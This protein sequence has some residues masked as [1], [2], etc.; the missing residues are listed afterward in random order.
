[1]NASVEK[2]PFLLIHVELSTPSISSPYFILE[3]TSFCIPIRPKA[4]LFQ[5]KRVRLG[6]RRGLTR[7]RTGHSLGNVV[8]G[9]RVSLFCLCAWPGRTKFLMVWLAGGYTTDFLRTGCICNFI[10][11]SC[12][13]LCWALVTHEYA[14]SHPDHVFKCCQCNI[15]GTSS[16]FGVSE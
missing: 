2:Y 12:L 13:R 16:C 10:S 6:V 14:Y 1:L 11:S 8:R 4:T 15:K 7:Q 9:Q 3:L 5:K